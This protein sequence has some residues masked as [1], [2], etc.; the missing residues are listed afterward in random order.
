[1][2]R[3]RATSFVTGAC[4][5]LIFAGAA[6]GAAA[7]AFVPDRGEGAVTVLYQSALVTQHLLASGARI[8]SGN[9]NSQGMLLDFNVGLGRNFGMSVGI[10]YIAAKYDGA[11]PHLLRP[12]EVP[13]YPTFK[14]LDNGEYH[15]TFQDF[16]LE[17]RYGMHKAG[18][19]I[20]PFVTQIIPSHTYQYL[21]HSAVGRDIYETQMGAYTARV[22]DPLLPRVFLQAGY[23]LGLEQTIDD[24]PRQRSI[25]TFES[26]YFVRQ[27]MSVRVFALG[28][29]QITH[30]G[31]DIPT[32]ARADYQGILFINHDRISRENLFNF[33]G[34]IAV[35]LSNR[36][37]L[38]ASVTRTFWGEN[39]HAQSAALTF[40]ISTGIGPQRRWGS[41][42]SGSNG[43]A[44]ADCHSGSTAE[45][46]LGKCVCLRK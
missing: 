44:S 45:D 22:L 37:D 11:S 43:E 10:P 18:W 8:D 31:I 5:V 3:R 25:V 9:I 38:V 6:A 12:S 39:G 33:G 13:L 29:L 17:L 24:I 35:S 19:A 27:S 14:V 26:G 7:Q 32:G 20:T 34:G 1:M 21:S 16:R 30:G 4:V 40:G 23:T 41:T 46:H 15:S 36:T 42:G 28:S 2:R